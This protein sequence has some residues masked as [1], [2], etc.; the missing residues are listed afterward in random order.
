MAPFEM[1]YGQVLQPAMAVCQEL[2][3]S[4][5][6]AEVGFGALKEWQKWAG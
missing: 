6:E 5:F 3:V 4:G 2:C 1:H